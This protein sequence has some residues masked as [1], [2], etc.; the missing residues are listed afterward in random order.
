M[1][2]SFLDRLAFAYPAAKIDVIVK[3]GLEFLLEYIPVVDQHYV[4]EKA[5]FPGWRGAEKFGKEISLQKKYD[6]MF[7][8]PES[9]SAASMS[10]AIHANKKISFGSTW[11]KW[12]FSNAYKKPNYVHRVDEYNA[13]LDQFTGSALGTAPVKLFAPVVSRREVVVI[14]VNS[15]ASSR[16]LPVAKA[17]EIISMLRSEINDVIYLIGAPKE[18]AFVNTIF[19]LLPHQSNIFMVAGQTTMPELINLMCGAKALLSTDSGPAHVANALGTP[20]L[21]LFGAGNELNTGPYN[22]KNAGTIRLGKLD[23]EPC[24]NNICKRF[25]EPECLL[26]LDVKKIIIEFKKILSQ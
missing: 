6:L 24:T 18:A 26:Q 21:V 19:G 3:K 12:F 14:N 9:F 11:Q 17:V 5:K 2:T 10:R 23:C 16:R 4:F 15:E 7:C 13:L 1:A 20:T 25:S 22:T 8:L